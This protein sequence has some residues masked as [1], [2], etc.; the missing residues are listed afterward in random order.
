MCVQIKRE[1]SITL[2][3]EIELKFQMKVK[4]IGLKLAIV[5]GI[6]FYNRYIDLQMILYT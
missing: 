1:K 3:N 2:C 6:Y 5:V 4:R